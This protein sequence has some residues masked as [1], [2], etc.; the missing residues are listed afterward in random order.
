[1]TNGVRSRTVAR[2][3]GVAVYAVGILIMLI[4]AGDFISNVWPWRVGAVDWRYGAIGILSTYLVT[5]IVG[6]LLV[7]ITAALLEHTA[8][9]R[10][11]A[12]ACVVMSMILTVAVI[13][14]LLDSLQVRQGVQ[15]TS[16]WFTTVSFM[17]AAVKHF[18]AI[19]TLAILGR[20]AWR[21]SGRDGEGPVPKASRESDLIV[22]SAK[23]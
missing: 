8:F 15:P 16:K 18:L 9:L 19:G 1:M 10:T 6:L 2:S 5:P 13:A 23:R 20:S 12:V 14:F 3:L 22:G 11:L 17:I 4:S 7:T 21:A